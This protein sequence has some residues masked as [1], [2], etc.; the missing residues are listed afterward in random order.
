NPW[1]GRGL[2]AAAG[3]PKG[4]ILLH[5]GRTATTSFGRPRPVRVR[6]PPVGSFS[7]VRRLNQNRPSRPH[8]S[9]RTPAPRKRWCSPRRP[10]TMRRS[11]RVTASRTLGTKEHRTMFPIP[12][13]GA[14]ASL[15][16]L[17]AF[18][19]ALGLPARPGLSA[20]EKGAKDPLDGVWS[21]VSLTV[22]GKT[23]S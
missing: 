5:R 14:L 4:V 22:G 13:R 18:A 8:R 1:R 12:S 21:A 7:T 10:V 20:Q 16:A 15:L 17:G 23:Y 19:A 11:C 3:A 9:G 6:A 2:R